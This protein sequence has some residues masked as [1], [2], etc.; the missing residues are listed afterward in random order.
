MQG[1][2]E[3]SAMPAKKGRPKKAAGKGSQVRIDPRVA[4]KARLVAS[5]MG[6]E[7]IE[8]LTGLLATG[9]ERDFRRLVK[10]TVEEE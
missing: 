7:L 1:T 8:Y 5:E 2:A 10:E 4:H 3:R 9:V 6:V